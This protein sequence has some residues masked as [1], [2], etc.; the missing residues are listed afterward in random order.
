MSAWLFREYFCSS[1]VLHEFVKRGLVSRVE[2]QVTKHI[3]P[4]AWDELEKTLN[5]CMPYISIPLS[6][7]AEEQQAKYRD[8]NTDLWFEIVID[9]FTED[10]VQFSISLWGYKYLLRNLELD[11]QSYYLLADRLDARIRFVD[12]WFPLESLSQQL[13]PLTERSCVLVPV[14]RD[15]NHELELLRKPTDDQIRSSCRSLF[16]LLERAL[17]EY[18][19][20]REWPGKS[21]NLDVLINQFERADALSKDTIELLRFV[22]KP[23]RDYTQHG[24]EMPVPIAKVVLATLIELFV[25]LAKEVNA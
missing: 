17:R 25:R 16:P 7:E 22:A 1:E 19:S 15:L 10:R 4:W 21:G 9:T 2:K 14:A 11:K 8:P 3:I 18:S 12:N 20:R 24:R 13:L 23:K 6:Q 5:A